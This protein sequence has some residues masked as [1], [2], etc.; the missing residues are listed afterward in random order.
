MTPVKLM[1]REMVIDDSGRLSFL[2]P[3]FETQKGSDTREE[4]WR[5]SRLGRK[6][7]ILAGGRLSFRC[8]GRA[9]QPTRFSRR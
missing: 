6:S 4:F 7:M 5:E 3:V 1:S 2:Q 8:Q 9:N